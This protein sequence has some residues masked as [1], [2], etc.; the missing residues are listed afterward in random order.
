MG[1]DLSNSVV[2]W[3]DCFCKSF[4]IINFNITQNTQNTQNAK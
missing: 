1:Q 4:L 2:V 3:N